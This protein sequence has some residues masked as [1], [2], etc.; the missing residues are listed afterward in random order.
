MDED[1]GRQKKKWVA[2]VLAVLLGQFGTHKF[3]LGHPKIGILY[4]VLTCT[5][6]GAFLTGWGSIIE[7]IL[8]AF[9][10]PEDFH[11]IYVLD[12]RAMF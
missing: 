6:I 7:G 11:R 9:K 2:I 8:Y 12:G 3:Y 5:I 1:A 10:S 4:I